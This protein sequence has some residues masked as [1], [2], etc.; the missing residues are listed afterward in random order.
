MSNNVI[1]QKNINPDDLSDDSAGWI[2]VIAADGEG[3]LY[4]VVG[5]TLKVVI[6]HLEDDTPIPPPDN[7]VL[8][9]VMVAVANLNVRELPDNT[10]KILYQVAENDLLD[11]FEISDVSSVN[12]PWYRIGEADW[13]AGWLTEK[14]A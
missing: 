10:S 13:V 9:Q 4:S 5:S 11:V 6:A 7:G 2:M 3:D 8:F 12:K 1:I 14:I